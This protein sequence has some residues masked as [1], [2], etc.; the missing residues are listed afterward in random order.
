VHSRPGGKGRAVKSPQ[1]QPHPQESIDGLV[2]VVVADSSWHYAQALGV[3]LQRELDLEVVG[4]AYSIEE[5]IA[6]VEDC[7]VDVA[8]LDVD[9]AA[10]TGVK[11]VE[12]LRREHRDVAVVAVSA[13]ADRERARRSL[14]LRISAHV[15]K[16]DRRDPERVAEAV[17]HARRGE[18]YL[19]REVQQLVAEIAARAPDPA[20]DSRLTS[21]EL[22]VVPLIAAG[23]RNREVASRL[24]VSEQTVRN[25]L[26]NIYR[27][28]GATNRTQM[29][30][31]A[32]RR[33]IFAE[34]A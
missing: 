15:V 2:R 4:V 16:R 28:L 10:S 19:D 18:A 31:E 17:R 20:L 13:T 22:E 33:G 26:T 23:L 6:F 12:L 32:R 9:L 11:A 5:L 24:G 30:A 21:R 25:H 27:K 34:R 1:P 29:T 14:A 3:A 7:S 8:V